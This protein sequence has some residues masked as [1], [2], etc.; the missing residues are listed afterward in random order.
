MFIGNPQPD[1]QSADVDVDRFDLPDPLT[2]II[3]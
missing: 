3:D 1:C 2:I